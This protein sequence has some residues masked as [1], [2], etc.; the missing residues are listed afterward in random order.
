MFY[1]KLRRC[2]SVFKTRQAVSIEIFIACRNA[3]NGFKDKQDGGIC[4]LPC[5]LSL[6]FFM[7]A[8]PTTK[9]HRRGFENSVD[10]SGRLHDIKGLRIHFSDF[11]QNPF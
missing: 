1:P 2:W 4:F 8:S 11:R 10:V 9:G 6:F 3:E 5:S 7:D